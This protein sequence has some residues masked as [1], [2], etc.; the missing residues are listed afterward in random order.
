MKIIIYPYK[1]G[2]ASAKELARGL[3]C[4]RVF[5]NK[6]YQ[7]KGNEVI[8]NWGASQEP[9]WAY[10]DMLNKPSQVALAS[11]KLLAFDSMFDG[12]VATPLF[13]NSIEMAEGLF[14]DYKRVYCRKSLSG[15]SGRGIIVASK[16]EELVQAPLYVAGISGL[17]DEYR[18][19]VFGDQVI[20][21]Q[22]KKRK[23]GVGVNTL[24]RNHSNGYI[25]AR[26]GVRASNK[27]CVQSIL[28]IRALGLDFGA[29]DLIVKRSDPEEMYVLE[30]NTAPGLTGTTL[31]KYIAAIG[32]LI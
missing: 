23:V 18:V 3:G 14:K 5:P 24:V 21:V 16:K 11:N 31:E 27:M 15:H 30:V 9:S 7:H 20:D 26:D 19:H 8:I 29:V 32:G 1:M 28:A 22:K 12:E 17:R 4:K 13:T 10:P 25:Y 6:A 2:S